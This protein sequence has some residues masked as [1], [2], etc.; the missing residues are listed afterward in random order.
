[1]TVVTLVTV[2]RRWL[3]W[4]VIAVNCSLQTT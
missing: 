3:C 4:L 2:V 1:M